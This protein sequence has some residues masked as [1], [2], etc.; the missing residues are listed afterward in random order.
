MGLFDEQVTGGIFSEKFAAEAEKLWFRKSRILILVDGNIDVLTIPRAVIG[1]EFIQSSSA[2]GIAV[3]IGVVKGFSSWFSSFAVTVA[4]RDGD[5]SPKEGFDI[6]GFRFSTQELSRFDQVWFFGWFPGNVAPDSLDPADDAYLDDPNNNP[7]SDAELEALS[8]WMDE[9]GG[10][11]GTG[12]HHFLGGAMCSKVPRVSAMRG[13]RIADGVTTQ[14]YA[15]RYETTRPRTPGQQAGSEPIDYPN[16]E[17]VLPQPIEWVPF[18]QDPILPIARP[19]P[20]LCHPRLGVINVLPDHMHEGHCFDFDDAGWQSTKRD[21]TFAFGGYSNAHFPTISGQR[22][23]PKVIA[24]G[25][26][27]ASPPLNFPIGGPQPARRIPLIAAYDGQSIGIGRVVVDST[28]HHWF[29]LNLQGMMD[30]AAETGQRTS[31]D[32][33]FRYYV[34]VGIYLASP[35][36]RAGMMLGWLKFHQ[37]QFFGREVVDLTKD[38]ATIGRTTIAY[39]RSSLGLCWTWQILDGF[40]EKF[41]IWPKVRSAMAEGSGGRFGLSFA[42]IEETVVGEIVKTVYSDQAELN[43]QIA[44]HGVV[45]ETPLFKDLDELVHKAARRG[46][47][48]ALRDHAEA[49]GSALR[50]SEAFEA[51]SEGS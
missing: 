50:Q 31:L 29:D 5:G 19:H 35:S 28:W 12:D 38:A 40:L 46:L 49:L 39:W 6:T 13:F 23:L 10:V 32:K 11:L 15:T 14:H 44:K 26:T 51:R 30:A 8:R 18:E 48:T 43:R 16:E 2:F 37:F 4:T 22:P 17:D 25:R 41:S 9:G 34:N 24:W 47:E 33:I 3:A 42:E 27:L 21:A 7:L 1:Q 20:I 36:W 45:T